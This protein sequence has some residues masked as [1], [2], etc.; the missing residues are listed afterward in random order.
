[1]TGNV[2]Y[3]PTCAPMLPPFTSNISGTNH[4]GL[5]RT[6]VSHIVIVDSRA[7]LAGFIIP[8]LPSH[9]VATYVLL[10]VLLFK[11]ST[12]NSNSCVDHK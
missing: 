1:M 12:K 11:S 3:S 8:L 2:R 10:R 4:P 9:K 7:S 6:T 5:D